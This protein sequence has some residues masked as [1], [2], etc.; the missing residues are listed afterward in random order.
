MQCQLDIKASRCYDVFMS[1][2]Y[3][4]TTVSLPLEVH[5]SLR[6]TAYKT[7]Q[8]YG[9]VIHEWMK[10]SQ[11]TLYVPRAKKQRMSKLFAELAKTGSDISA[12]ESVREDRDR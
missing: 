10:E 7:K 4:R 9:E 8:S 2:K 3:I 5:D 6:A 12:V 1:A 11:S